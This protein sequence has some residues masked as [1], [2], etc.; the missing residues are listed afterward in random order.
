MN[1]VRNKQIFSKH[2]KS[3]AAIISVGIH[4]ILI[5]IAVSF[6][7]VTVIQKEDKS[8]ESKPVS[9]SKINLKKLQ[10]PVT[11][12][13]KKVQKPKLRKRI[14]VQSKL[15]QSMPDIKMPEISG[16]KG[17]LGSSSAGGLG[18]TGNLGFSMPEINLFGVKSKGEKVFLILDSSDEIMK[19]EMGGIPAY[20][21]I[22]D[23][24]VRIID[25]LPPTTLFN[26]AIYERGKASMLFPQLVAASGANMKKTK[27]W[28][29]PLNSWHEGMGAKDY[30]IKT[31][32]SGGQELGTELI[33]EPIKIDSEW[34]RP[35]LYAM[36]Q[37]A[38]AIFV[39]GAGWGHQYHRLKTGSMSPSLQKKY[40]E[41]CKKAEKLFEEENA[42]RMKKGEPP[43][44]LSNQN[45]KVRTYFPEIRFPSGNVYYNYTPAEITEVLKTVRQDF[46]PKTVSAKSGL[47][48]NRNKIDYTLNVI[49]FTRKSGTDFRQSEPFKKMANLNRGVS[50][51]LR[52]RGARELN[53]PL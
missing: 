22:K 17:G 52:S 19:D 15:N 46:K 36:K 34:V 10:V 42:E 13:K 37:Q 33:Q 35:V 32:G 9:R 40:D 27:V 23:E 31:L 50:N 7:A 3:S 5:L 1:K 45:D 28:L 41:Y 20:T 43:R 51:H 16:V 25:G 11:I 14:V 38:D 18:E 44:V 24:L 47:R 12:K 21:L 39:L 30:G 26:I 8:F 29:D 2:T 53:V 48:K 4:A 6:V 49:Q